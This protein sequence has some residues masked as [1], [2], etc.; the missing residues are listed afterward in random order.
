MKIL[1]ICLTVLYCISGYAQVTH[2]N[3]LMNKYTLADIKQSIV[4]IEKFKPF[5]TTP[6]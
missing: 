6:E 1:I 3:L 2:R 4:P 5:P